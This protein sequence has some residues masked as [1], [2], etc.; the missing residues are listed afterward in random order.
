MQLSL[1]I[2]V[3]ENEK[4]LHNHKTS[5]FNP[6]SRFFF[7]CALFFCILVPPGGA[8]GHKTSIFPFLSIYSCDRTLT[9]NTMAT[10]KLNVRSGHARLSRSLVQKFPGK[11]SHSSDIYA[12]AV[13]KFKNGG[14][15]GKREDFP[16]EDSHCFA[17][18]ETRL[19]TLFKKQVDK[20]VIGLD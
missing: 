2:A 3:K 15:I 16:R 19:S 8:H 14:L 13:N 10:A 5:V 12:C 18:K 6:E 20:V 11:A 17:V 9:S 7:V 4:N 1:S